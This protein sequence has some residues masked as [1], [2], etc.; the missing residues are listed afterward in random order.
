MLLLPPP[1]LLSARPLAS[2][3]RQGAAALGRFRSGGRRTPPGA[4]LPQPFAFRLSN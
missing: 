1:P 3:V 4:L 2:R